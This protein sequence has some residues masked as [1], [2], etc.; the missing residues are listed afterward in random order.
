MDLDNEFIYR[1]HVPTKERDII[2]RRVRS[3]QKWARRRFW[4]R[5]RAQLFGRRQVR[6]PANRSCHSA[7]SSSVILRNVTSGTEKA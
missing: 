2:M 1:A 6:T 3:H 7:R 4:L 5:L